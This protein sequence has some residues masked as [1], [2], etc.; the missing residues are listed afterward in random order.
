MDKF[1]RQRKK[2][3]SGKS[4]T[5]KM[6]KLLL[7]GF[8]AA[9]IVFMAIFWYGNELIHYYFLTSDFIYNA[10]RPFVKDLSNYVQKGNIAATDANSLSEWA[11]SRNI[12]RVMIS[13]KRVL[14]YDSAYPDSVI[15]GQA[16]SEALHRLWQYFYVVSFADGDADVYID[17]DYEKIH[18][19]LF[20]LFDAI[21]SMF[22]WI[23]IFVL[24]I[25][26]EVKYIQQLSR[27]VAQIEHGTLNVNI[28]V[29]GEDELAVL[30]RGLNQ[31]RLALIEKEE[32]EKQM[33]A[34]Q[35]ELVLGMA[36]DL[37]TPLTGLMSFLEIAKM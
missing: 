37:R 4:L 25:R 2:K 19:L 3:F 20:Y 26:R 27:C 36:H 12:R 15:F 13:R 1:I 16:R 32:N 8:F 28:P 11:L 34:A 23:L 30:S 10:E 5:G 17:A 33:K 6:V 14:L 35:E 22:V 21:L 9:I 7:F 31:M 24:G 18:Y 29:K